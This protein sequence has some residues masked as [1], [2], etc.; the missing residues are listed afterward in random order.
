MV[1][2]FRG[3]ERDKD[4]EK[5]FPVTRLVSVNRDG[6]KQKMLLQDPFPP[7]GQINDRIIDWTPEAPSSVLIEKFNPFVGLRVLERRLQR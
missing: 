7:S 3:R 1:C 6:S 5:I 4:Q 2:S